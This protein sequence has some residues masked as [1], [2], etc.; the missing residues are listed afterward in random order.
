MPYSSADVE[1]AQ[2]PDL[3]PYNSADGE[4]AQLPDLAPH[5]SDVMISD[6]EEEV[7]AAIAFADE[8]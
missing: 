6:S 2:L 1:N 7:L 8:N 3:A 4:N 5:N